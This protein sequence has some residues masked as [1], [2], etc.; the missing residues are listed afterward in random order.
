MGYGCNPQKSCLWKLL[1]FLCSLKTNKPVAVRM[2]HP[3]P[4]SELFPHSHALIL[5]VNHKK[6]PDMIDCGEFR[7]DEVVLL[8]SY[9]PFDA[10]IRHTH[11]TT[12][13]TKP[14]RYMNK[15]GTLGQQDMIASTPSSLV[16]K[17][18]E[19]DLR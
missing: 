10:K 7:W 9:M 3:F 19:T 14:I 1:D 5:E 12:T 11:T 2:D 17:R 18:K 15:Q 4:R 16:V 6:R 8:I 13:T